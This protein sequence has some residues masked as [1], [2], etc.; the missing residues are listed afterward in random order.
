M[1]SQPPGEGGLTLR[2]T[3]KILC[4]HGD[5]LKARKGSQGIL[6][7]RRLGSASFTACRRACSSDVTLSIGLLRGLLEVES[8]LFLTEDTFNL[9]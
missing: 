1:K 9:Q 5:K 6:Q 8:Q 3:Q 7:G 4:S 2:P